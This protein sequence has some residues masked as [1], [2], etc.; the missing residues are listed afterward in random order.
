MWVVKDQNTESRNEILSLRL[1]H[2]LEAPIQTLP[3]HEGHLGN[4][5]WFWYTPMPNQYFL[6][7]QGGTLQ[8]RLYVS[9]LLRSELESFG[10]R[11]VAVNW[12]ASDRDQ[13]QAKAMRLINTN[14]VFVHDNAPNYISGTVIGD[15][16]TYNPEIQR[17]PTTS[18]RNQRG[19]ISGHC[20]CDWAAFMNTPRTRQ[21]KQYQNA[22]CSHL[23]A[24]WWLA[25]SMPVEGQDVP[26][27]GQPV[28]ND[29]KDFQ[30]LFKQPL[31]NFAP[32]APVPNA[33][34]L[35]PRPEMQVPQRVFDPSEAEGWSAPPNP[36]TALP[37]APPPVVEVD[38]NGS[39]PGKKLP[40]PADPVQYPGGTYSY[41]LSAQQFLEGSKVQTK[42]DDWGT[43]VG[44]PGYAGV[45]QY[46][47][48]PANSIGE[49]RGVHP[50]TGMVEVFFNGQDFLQKGAMQAMGATAWYLPNELMPRPDLRGG[51]PMIRR[52]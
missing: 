17:D 51:S 15:H 30:P 45:G 46:L 47:K 35:T 16:G 27:G 48:I 2:I 10:L 8:D 41:R 18:P 6:Q 44:D 49:V 21:W 14:K 42:N 19:L 25:Q 7:T 39:V 38:P 12:N 5:Y 3:A 29:M 13:V 33:P 34:G 22:P 28:P 24:L 26:Q 23:I 31:R 36:E 37:Q 52:T 32:N 9:N 11:K 50:S 1:S 43:G 40:S 20:Q 4:A